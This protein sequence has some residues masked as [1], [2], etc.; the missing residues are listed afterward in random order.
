[1][2]DV[3]FNPIL[4]PAGNASGWYIAYMED[5]AL[6]ICDIFGKE[7]F[8]KKI[9]KDFTKTANSFCAT[10]NER[11]GFKQWKKKQ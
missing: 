3:Y 1:M 4:I 10:L 11:K 2:S 5:G 7:Q 8:C 6:I 9:V